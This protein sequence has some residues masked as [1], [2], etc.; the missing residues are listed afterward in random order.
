MELRTIYD[1]L[2]E[3]LQN[4]KAS[5]QQVADGAAAADPAIHPDTQ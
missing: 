1:K 5:G 2:R 3:K 4:K